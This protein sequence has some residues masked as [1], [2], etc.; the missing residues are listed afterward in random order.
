[1]MFT[2]E[3]IQWYRKN[4]RDLPWRRTTDPYA[5][6]VSEIILQQTR[7][8]QGL[9]Y[10]VQF[11]DKFPEVEA[12]A[13]ADESVL[14][15]IWQGLGYYSRARNMH[16]TAKTVIEKFGGKFPSD[17][18]SLLT[19]PGIGPYTA[20]AIASFSAEE[21]RAVV[22]GNVSRVLARYFGISES[23]TSSKGQASIQGLAQELIP[24]E[25]PA[26]YNQAIMEY[27]ALVCTPKNTACITCNLH[28]GCFAF[29]HKLVQA[30]PV[31][32]KAKRKKDRYFHYFVIRDQKDRIRLQ[33]RKQPDVWQHLYELPLFETSDSYSIST[34]LN[35]NA[36]IEKFGSNLQIVFESA[37][38]TQILSH[39][40]IHAKFYE[41]QYAEEIGSKNQNADYVFIKD[42]DN[43]A[44]P[45]IIDAFFK[46]YFKDLL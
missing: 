29:K 21:C 20:A 28:P 39:Q 25:A 1:M 7:V 23:I 18:K 31:K 36:F 41:V 24:C 10:Y 44:K 46:D 33:Q 45:K 3:L 2:E 15:R 38:K 27:G 14:L 11:M 17:Y 32:N 37:P 35:N 12:L 6:W 26:E 13:E 5:I 16:K 42:L 40:K 19:L 8:A 43:L 9:P 22:D 30:L 4:K 34:L